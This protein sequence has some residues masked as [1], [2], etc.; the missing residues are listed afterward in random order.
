MDG[1]YRRERI[2]AAVGRPKGINWQN[3]KAEY[4]TG[5]ISQRDLAAKLGCGTRKVQEKARLEGWTA[6]RR[7]YRAKVAEKS[8]QKA[9]AAA[10]RR[11]ERI[12]NITDTL[13]DKIEASLNELDM[14]LAKTVNRVKE[15]E[16]NNGERPDKPTK[17]IV[18]EVETITAYQS[19]IDRKGLQQLAA[20]L[21]DIK[22]VQM[23]RSALDDEE[24]R[25]RIE[26]LRRDA[27][28]DKADAAASIEI[29]GLPEDY[30]S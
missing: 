17:E 7:E 18:N 3:A 30:K 5:S 10:V 28:D 13:L 26:K 16:Y 6:A 27:R 9:E 4:V 8:V 22:D 25:A 21:K 1:A 19:M 23:L 12:C 14:H 20:A 29:I 15:I 2:G 24:Q 11:A